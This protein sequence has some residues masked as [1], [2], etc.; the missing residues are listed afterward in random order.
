MS[1]YVSAKFTVS[2]PTASSN[3]CTC[4]NIINTVYMATSFFRTYR[5]LH[6]K[7]LQ[8]SIGNHV[9][10]LGKLLTKMFCDRLWVVSIQSNS[11]SYIV[12]SDSIGSKDARF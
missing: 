10:G 1:Y 8:N 12:V 2:E 11:H 4:V 5:S 3:L 6:V 7:V 9:K